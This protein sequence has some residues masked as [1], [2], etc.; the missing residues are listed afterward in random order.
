MLSLQL[1][2]NHSFLVCIV[3]GIIIEGLTIE[4]NKGILMHACEICAEF[5]QFSWS[6]EKTKTVPR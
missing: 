2:S 3:L 1:R 4:Y 5:Y 6:R